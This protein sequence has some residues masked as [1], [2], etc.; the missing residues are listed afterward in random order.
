LYGVMAF[1]VAQRTQ[2]IGVRM[3]LGATP[4]SIAQLVLAYAARYTVAGVIIGLVA[5]LWATR[6]LRTML[7][8]VT[9]HDP[10]MLAAAAAALL[11]IALLA[12]WVPSRRASKVDPMV[13]LRQD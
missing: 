12:A 9:P 10:A 7:F 6:W 13:A 1:L 8:Q 5:A 2:E 4:R 3:A 11:S